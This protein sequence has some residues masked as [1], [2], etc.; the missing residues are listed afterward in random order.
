MTVKA[1]PAR[2]IYG[3]DSANKVWVKVKVDSD[4]QIHIT[5][6][7]ITTILSEVQNASYGL[8][9][10]K[11]AIDALSVGGATAQEVWEYATRALTDKTGFS[12]SGTKTT[13]DALNDLALVDIEATTVLAKESDVESAITTAH[14]TT[15]GKV[16]AVQSDVTAVKN[17]TDNL[18]SDPADESLLEAAITSAHSTTDGLVTTVDGVV[19][20]IKSKTDNLPSD[21]A[22]ASD[23]AADLD[24]HLSYVDFWSVTDDVIA[25]TATADQDYNLPDVTVPTLPTGFTIYR[26]VLLFK[27]SL[28]RDTSGSDNGIDEAGL[29][30][31]KADGDA[32]FDANGITAYTILD[33]MWLVDVTNVGRDRGGDAF[34]GATDLSSKV[35]GAD[36]YN[37]RLDSIS[38]DG[39]NLELHDVAVG[40]RIYFY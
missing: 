37:L 18:P 5:N 38:A 10:I 34:V 36:T 2:G 27:C 16:D 35:T 15:N 11:D 6:T 30:R 19:D 20:A 31:I 1:L 24:R 9:A 14:T 25:V 8:S 12:I 28:I 4:G 39:S 22:D 17:K 21:P 32:N 23:I 7:D 29:I 33:N 3:Y 13:L 26:V 40:L